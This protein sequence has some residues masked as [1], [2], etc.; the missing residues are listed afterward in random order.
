MFGL[1]SVLGGIF[2]GVVVKA[3]SD[4][5]TTITGNPLTKEESASIN[6]IADDAV[7]EAS[8]QFELNK[9]AANHASLFIAG[10]RPFSLWLL[11]LIMLAQCLAYFTAL[12]PP[13]PEYLFGQM[14]LT[15]LGLLGLRS[16]EKRMGIDTKGIIASVKKVFKR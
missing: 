13:L 4:A 3:A 16:V 5:V 11:P 6:A 2:K 15:W 10:A 1:G 9:Q 12:Y 14:F 8:Q 7:T